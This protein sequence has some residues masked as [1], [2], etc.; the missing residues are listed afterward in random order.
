M[1]WE[2][3]NQIPHLL[4]DYIEKWANKRPDDIA[5]IDADDGRWITWKQFKNMID[6]IA[7]ELIEMGFQKGDIC[8][9]MLPLLPE[10]I[11]FEY[12]CFKL[13]MIVCPL[14]VRLK[15]HE[16]VRCVKL[17]RSARRI[18]Y[19]HPDDTD[20]ED[21]W[22]RKKFYAFKQIARAVRK[23]IP[24]IKDFIQFGPEEDADK[25]TM[26]ILN[27]FKKARAHYKKYLK[28]PSLFEEKMRELE[29]RKNSVDPLKDGCM[30]I[31]TT[32][33]TGFP[34]PAILTNGGIICQ[35]MCM[36]KAFKFTKEDRMLVN[37]PPSHV[38]CQTEQLMTTIFAGGISVIL[39]AF[40]AEKSLQSIEKYKV[41]VFGQ[42]PSLFVMEWRLKRKYGAF[43]DYD[44]YD[45][46]SLRLAIYGGQAVSR[47]FL[48]R[49]KKM[50][51][52]FGTGLGLT[53]MSG[54]V[55]YTPFK[56]DLTVEE[57]LDNVGYDFPITPLS[58]REPMKENGYAG[59]E[60]PIGEIGEVCYSGPQVFL[61][62]YGNEEATRKTISKDG[63]CYTGDLGFKDDKGYLHLVGRS[64]FV[65]KPK[66]YQV[67]PPEVEEYIMQLP[68]VSLAAVIGYPHEV[69]SEGVIAFVEPKK[70]KK[71]SI[72]KLKEHCKGLAA[73]KRPSLF[74]IVDEIPL[75]RV[76]KTDYQELKKMVVP[77][78][79]K[80]RAEGRWDAQK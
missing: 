22:G 63:I 1:S 9:T 47:E 16:V 71:I 50:A 78:I 48:E 25:G 80:E 6:L 43:K 55:S 27:F 8:V 17:L 72:K 42:I 18:L 13:G 39:H 33:S 74:I 37:L 46:S 62:Y 70:N 32:G 14:D 77:Y 45:L 65:I 67:Y 3:F 59:D 51:P 28:E 68:E 26:G 60:K 76:D 15:E 66:G 54:F 61:G 52:Y 24:E 58:I 40:K 5:I 19:M 11:F 30:I 4:V 44:E 64:K 10:H 12:A 29:K 21:K 31:Y 53:E 7:L 38:G 57:V 20:S 36:A 35:N 56:E 23:E 69:F 49:L 75:N 2:E 41:T 73:Y 79:K 34:K